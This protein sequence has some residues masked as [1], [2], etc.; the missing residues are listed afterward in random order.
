MDG[1]GKTA[2]AL[3]GGDWIEVSL[4]EVTRFG[5]VQ[6]AWEADRTAP[7]R[8]LGR[9]GSDDEWKLIGESP[10]ATDLVEEVFFDQAA[11]RYLRI[12]G[13]GGKGLLTELV[14]K[15]PVETWNPA[16][17]FEM[18]ARRTPDGAFPRWLRREQGYWTVVGEPRSNLVSLLDEDGRVEVRKDGISITPALLV[19]GRLVTSKEAT[20]TQSLEEG[21]APLPS[22]IWKW[23]GI[24]LRIDAQSGGKD[25]TDVR[26]TVESSTATSSVALLLAARPLQVNPPWQRGGFS[27][28]REAIISPE[29]NAV[30]VNGERLIFV[31][32][33]ATAAGAI[34]REARDILNAL[35]DGEDIALSAQE[36][37]GLVSAGLMFE[38]NEAG[39][40]EVVMRLRL[41]EEATEEF[42]PNISQVFA[43]R[44]ASEIKRWRDLTGDWE[45][46]VPDA[47]LSNFVRSNLAYLLINM[48]GPAIQPGTRNY[49]HSWIRDG[50]ISATSMVLF[51][52]EEPVRDY[53]RWFGS[54][55][56]E[57]GFVPFIVQA[58]DGVMPEW[59]ADWAEHDSFGQFAYLVREYFEL[60]GDRE[61]LDAVWPKMKAAIE[62]AIALRQERLGPEWV[63]TEFEGILPRS[64]S[65][66]G[67]FPAQ[68]S[69]WDDFTLLRGFDD[70]VRIAD[71]VGDE[72][73]RE[74][75]LAE[76]AALRE[77][78]VRSMAR[79]R[80][81]HGL[82]VIPASADL[83]DFDPTSTSIG[84]MFADERDTLDSEA[85][86]ATYDRYLEDVRLRHFGGKSSS[87]TAYEARTVGALLRLG[88]A[89][90]ALWLLDVL[91]A[92]ATRPAGWNHMGEVTHPD[93]RMPSYIGDM[94]HTWIGSGV[95]HAI[96]DLFVYEDRGGLVLGAGIADE[97]WKEGVSVRGLKTWWGDV[98]YEAREE[99]GRRVIRLKSESDPPNGWK[100]VPGVTVLHDPRIAAL[101]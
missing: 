5:G 96:R 56:R 29:M 52:M 84:I 28:I 66:E 14:L 67:Y 87:Y 99:D 89:E 101:K 62:H 72:A 45:I 37:N 77:A 40:G 73:A 11:A 88:R 25:L 63:G 23:E 85:L 95:I 4:P 86:K 98:S 54:L 100:T 53:V 22:V 46:N 16:R 59:T 20:V 32:P 34:G 50:S 39:M 8:L 92:D 2:L 17:H 78:L 58:H 1:S 91:L 64:N 10:G 97:W 70:G 43:E 51:G 9:E 47:R 41:S 21:W 27:P 57:D 55:V 18:I 60:T 13:L 19:E 81:R 90:E 71:L 65:H 94:P 79:V 69:Y 82:A 83:G 76:G 68:H 31:N 7:W 75:F 49:E 38:M 3:E 44:R 61:T 24:T 74:K 6:L 80:E 42:P 30:A 48:Q 93:P 35:A 15:G 36:S 33:R 26:Y 12:E